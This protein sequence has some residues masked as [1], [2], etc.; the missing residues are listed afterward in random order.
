MGFEG[1]GIL[2][3][4]ITISG[5]VIGVSLYGMRSFQVS[6]IDGKYSDRTYKFSRIITSAL[7]LVIC[8]LF[9]LLNG[10]SLYLCLC[11][12]VYMCFKITESAS[13]IFQGI[14]QRALRMDYIGISFIIKGVITL[15]LFILVVFLTNDLLAGI[16][17]LFVS[18][19]AIV[20]FYDAHKARRFTQTSSNSDLFANVKDLLKECLP[21]AI[22]VL[23]FNTVALIPRY[24]LEL[25]MGVEA[26]G[27]YATVA[28]PVVIVQVSA[29]FVFNPLITPFAQL[30]N[31]GDSVGFK[32]LL[33]KAILFIL[34]LS[35]VSLLGFGLL[36]DW[37][38]LLLF[39]PKIEP[40]T[41]LL[42]P[43]VICTILVAVSWFL[44]TILVVLRKLKM[45]LLASITSFIVV[46]STSFPFIMVFEYNGA[47]FVL[48]LGLGVFVLICTV[49]MV[50]AIR[51]SFKM[52]H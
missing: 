13:D 28:M 1:A 30:L 40:F 46:I 33:F 44:S 45:L 39:G 31:K 5:V 24:F 18:S 52:A 12:L 36:G 38:L 32:S 11:I 15:V 9:V 10:Y 48:I 22:Y 21:I 42:V 34:I 7:A 47:N 49:V 25:Q 14:L 35:V 6:D 51:S 20:I 37:F 4:A 27:A 29:S 17:V 2:T 3:L 43:L 19:A 8:A 26:L 41:Y 16:L 50:S 23:L